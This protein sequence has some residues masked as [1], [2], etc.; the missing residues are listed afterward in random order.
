MVFSI[1]FASPSMLT[2]SRV[3]VAWHSVAW[4]PGMHP[5]NGGGRSFPSR[6][7]SFEK[8]KESKELGGI[9]CDPIAVSKQ[10]VLDIL[11]LGGRLLN[12]MTRAPY[13]G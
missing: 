8:P 12:D 9:H 10:G 11:S 3:R 7:K 4:D 6:M 13:S 5:G 2:T 1:Q